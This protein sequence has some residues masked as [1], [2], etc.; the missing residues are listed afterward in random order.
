[1]TW[2]PM[3]EKINVWKAL[4][5]KYCA[6]EHSLFFEV[7]SGT[8]AAARTR[9]DAIAMSLWPSR[10][11]EIIGIEVKVSRSDWLREKANPQKAQEIMRYCDRWYLA[12]DDAA[13]VQTGELPPTW[14]LLVPKGQKLVIA[15]EA[16]KLQPE[17]TS[18]AFIAS[19]LRNAADGG[20]KLVHQRL[21]A[22]R[23]EAEASARARVESEL[24]H[25]K[26]NADNERRR[27]Q[28]F[29]QQVQAFCDK[30]GMSIYEAERL[31]QIGNAVRAVLAADTER[32]AKA[33]ENAKRTLEN[34]VDMV[35]HALEDLKRAPGRDEVQARLTAEREAERA[36]HA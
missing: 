9:A 11:L 6:P 18:R 8:G 29:A 1:M 16:P 15:T 17:P 34:A 21:N 24:S 25:S 31:P 36:R 19:L 2:W 13:I 30:L 5:A 33:A 28:E 32:F 7:A 20:E 14:G 35:T 3:A 23:E 10:G 26:E 12:V 4:A 22:L 27:H